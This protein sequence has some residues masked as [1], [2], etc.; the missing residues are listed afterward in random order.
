MKTIGAD[1]WGNVWEKDLAEYQGVEM[2][3]AV[4]E[5]ANS[6][7]CEK[8]LQFLRNRLGGLSGLR[9][10]EVG[11]GG[12]IYSLI[13]ARLGAK[14]TLLDFSSAALRLVEQNLEAL[15]LDGDLV[16]VDAFNLPQEQLETYDIAMSF[17]TIEHYRYPER[18]AICQS[19]VD[20][21]RPG[22]VVIL[23]T[24]N[25]LFIPHEILKL[26]LIARGK[27]F[28]GYEGSFSR[29]EF[30][31]ISRKLGL[32]Q[33]TLVGSSWRA[34]VRRYLN[35]V[36]STRTYRRLFGAPHMEVDVSTAVP[37]LQT[38]HWLDDYLGHDLALLGIKSD[39]R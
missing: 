16:Q 34:D 8:I 21:V 5:E 35:I 23:S 36:R 20:M 2:R 38:H 4:D 32:V 22:G 24:P 27:W 13:F 31:R 18:L 1:Q 6:V 28:L 39:T 30:Q 12:A 25:I 7:R 10:V 19:H 15:G 11:C 14:I 29:L 33:V 17:G 9:T 37:V 26:M 3:A